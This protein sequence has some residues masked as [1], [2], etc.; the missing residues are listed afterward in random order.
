MLYYYAYSGHK[1]GL[2]CVRRGVAMIKALKTEGVEMHLLVNDFRAGLAA[3]ELGV[4][5]AV[6]VETILDVDAVA[7]RGD[8]VILDT[9]EGLGSRLEQYAD[10]FHPLFVVSDES[11]RSSSFGEILLKPFCGEE[12]N[13]IETP[14][15]DLEYSQD[16]TE[17][18][19]QKED[20]VLFIFGDADYS[21]EILKERAFFEGT[22]MD[23]MLGYYFFVKYESELSKLF[24]QLYEPEEYREQLAKR[25]KILSR[26]AQSALEAK[27]AG[28]D[29]AYIRRGEEPGSLL[30]QLES[31]SI[32][33]IDGFDKKN[34]SEWM[35]SPFDTQKSSKIPNNAYKGV[36]K[37]L[38]L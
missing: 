32:N 11:D 17:E 4:E 12:E 13:C 26:S 15:I 6:T 25:R 1:Y 29:V 27:A 28:A 34:L 18:K 37:I 31:Y 5:G 21:K 14:I 23:L 3:R 2:D 8:S 7:E 19:V 10:R 35:H 20:R 22:G 9:P 24:H 38:N 30:K 16:S 33:I 36:L